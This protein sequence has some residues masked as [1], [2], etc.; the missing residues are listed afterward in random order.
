M[1][2][3]PYPTYKPS[4]APWLGKVP[5]HWDVRRLKDVGQ[6]KGGAGFR[7]VTKAKCSM[8]YHIFKV[9]DMG[10]GANARLMK[11]WRHTISA[12]TA[13]T[14]G[15]YV[16]PPQTIVFAK[17]GAALMLNRR[18]LL[19]RPSCIDNNMMG[20]VP[21]SAFPAWM[22][23]WMRT[24]DFGIIVNP[25][26][27]PSVN[28]GQVGL[29]A[30]S[31]PPLPEQRAIA[32]FLD[33]ETAKID[34]LVAKKERLIELLQEEKQA[35]VNQAVTRSLDPS[36]RLKPSGVEW[37]GDVPEHWEVSRVK[38]E[39]ISLNHRRVPLSAVERGAM[40]IRRYDYYGASGVIDDVEDY[41]FDDQLLLIAEDG[42]NLVLRNLPLAIIAHGK[43]WVNNH[44]HI[45]KPRRGNLEYLAVVMERLNY[46]LGFREQH[47]R[48]LLSI[49]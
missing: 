32:A 17:V 28:E 39:F 38:A 33:R 10:V 26:A 48:N 5:E 2:S 16:F 25:G 49:G 41:L 11:E 12:E 23:Y 4:G 14:L 27:V 42:A 30:T 46:T 21:H 35:V 20:F 44:A 37:L 13:E 47:N 9:G 22:L 15:A 24:I 29:M 19:I 40:S 36:V 6:L 45:L 43:F 3:H 34:A 8:N 1:N 7:T 18:R 31:V